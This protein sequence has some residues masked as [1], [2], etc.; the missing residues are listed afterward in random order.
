M[1]GIPTC[2]IR[3]YA[4]PNHFDFLSI[5]LMWYGWDPN[6]C[7]EAS[8]TKQ[9]FWFSLNISYVIW[10]GSQLGWSGFMHHTNILIF[11]QYLSCDMDGIPTCVMR[12]HAPRKHFD[13][14]SISLMW[15]GWDPNLCDQAW[16]YLPG[17]PPSLSEET[18]VVASMQ[19]RDKSYISCERQPCW[20]ATWTL[21][22]A[23]YSPSVHKHSSHMAGQSP[24]PG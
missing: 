20:L 10:M 21:R 4:P 6:L 7:D 13:F 1:D 5:S 22:P 23:C 16:R 14:L 8:C 12:P 17:H 9:T 18:G 11:S 3:P 2:V 19:Y 24:C 15:Y